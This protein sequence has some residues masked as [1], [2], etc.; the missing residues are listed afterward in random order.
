MTTQTNKGKNTTWD[1]IVKWYAEQSYT[2]NIIYSV[3]ASVVIIGALFKILHWPG[4]SYV[5]MAGMFTEAFLFVLGI[6]EKP[7]TTYRWENVFPQ[8]TDVA[9]DTAHSKVSLPTNNASSLPQADIDSLQGSTKHL[10]QTAEQLSSLGNITA[11]TDKLITTMTAASET[12]ERFVQTQDSLTAATENIAKQYQ[13]IE[14]GIANA[15]AQTQTYQKG[16]ELINAQLSSINSVYELQLKDMQ[17]QVAACNSHTEHLSTL[18]RDMKEVLAQADV[19]KVQ[20]SAA[21]EA[22]KQYAIAQQKLAE[23]I[24]DLN[25]VYGNMLNAL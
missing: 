12:T 11:A 18:S 9:T 2:V 21:A 24:A 8:I 4:A 5:L 19:L 23:Q 13:S 7:H 25:K 10:T 22:S 3:G 15:A 6:F 17:A 14:T 1:K 20:T 16:I